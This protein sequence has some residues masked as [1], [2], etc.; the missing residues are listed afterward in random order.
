MRVGDGGL[1][2]FGGRPMGFFAAV[3]GLVDFVR[4]AGALRVVA[5]VAAFFSASMFF[6]FSLASYSSFDGI[7]NVIFFKPVVN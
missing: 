3:V 1:E 7:F 2:D 4:A 6:C 5:L